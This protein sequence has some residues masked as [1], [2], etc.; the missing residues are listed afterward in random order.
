MKAL[1]RLIEILPI[2]LLIGAALVCVV[3]WATKEIRSLSTWGATF[4]DGHLQITAFLAVLA[5]IGY[6]GVSAI[7]RYRAPGASSGLSLYV[8]RL[9]H[10]TDALVQTHT[11][12]SLQTA[13]SKTEDQK[14]I[15]VRPLPRKLQRDT[16]LASTELSKCCLVYGA[17]IPPAIVH[18]TIVASSG[19]FAHRLTITDYPKLD[20]LT[21]L[22]IDAIKSS[23]PAARIDDVVVSELAAL[24]REHEKLF[25]ELTKSQRE[26]RQLQIQS[27]P[28]PQ[29]RSLQD[30]VVRYYHNQKKYLVCIGINSYH[31]L[32]S[33][34]AA[35]EDA[36][37]VNDAYSSLFPKTTASVLI[38]NE[39]ATKQN[40]LA[41]L[42]RVANQSEE[43]DQVVL[44]YSGH[45]FTKDGIG[46][47]APT[48]TDAANIEHT[49]LSMLDVGKLFSKMKAKQKLM[50]VDSCYAGAFGLFTRGL[51]PI[52]TFENL[53]IGTG[54]VVI[55]AGTELQAVVD[56]TEFGHGLF[57]YYLVE[58]M[59]GEAD[60]DGDRLITVTDLFAY[61]RR[62][63]VEATRESGF[64][65]TPAMHARNLT[66]FVVT[67][68]PD[69][70]SEPTSHGAER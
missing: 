34:R 13:L 11:V 39:D 14:H 33:L 48:D 5:T 21:N 20:R 52:E 2:P 25:S 45:G 57:T 67:V 29:V 53:L 47:L 12:E 9:E 30:K 61:V 40:V 4:R 50:L 1:E 41:T 59:R 35:A 56:N 70:R 44:F 42:E 58:G 19:K 51:R 36:I 22:I 24:R 28:N 64:A 60:T 65:Q 46:Y 7:W 69:G 27:S 8:A 63:L 26:L 23:V 3:A 32:P 37:L 49:A 66:D 16:A 10:D 6:Y 62:R 17:F 31:E 54:E 38:L 15:R 55:T 43:G 68:T 18:Y